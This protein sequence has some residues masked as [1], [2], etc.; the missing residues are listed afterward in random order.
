MSFC[1]V[2]GFHAV[3]RNINY[4]SH[5]QHENCNTADILRAPFELSQ[6]AQFLAPLSIKQQLH[7]LRNVHLPHLAKLAGQDGEGNFITHY[8]QCAL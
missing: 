5:A 1:G 4:I 6:Q 7:I 8:V 2:Q 3:Q